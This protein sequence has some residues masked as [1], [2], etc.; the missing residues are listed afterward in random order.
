MERDDEQSLFTGLNNNYKLIYKHIYL[1]M[2]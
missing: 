1:F 2:A